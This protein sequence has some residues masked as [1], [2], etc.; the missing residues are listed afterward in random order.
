[1]KARRTLLSCLLGGVLAQAAGCTWVSSKDV[2]DRRGQVDD[3]ADGFTA[4]EDC[5]EANPNINPG[6]AEVWYDGIDQDCGRED[7]YDS[8]AD[9]YVR[10]VDVGKATAAVDGS[11]ALPGGDCDDGVATT[12]PG[13][14]DAW[15]DG[16]DTDCDGAD[17]FDADADG[18]VATEHEGLATENAPGT[19]GLPAGDCDDAVETVHPGATDAW[20]DGVDSDCRGQDDFDAD[21]D[22]YVRSED[23]GRATTYVPGSGGLP[24]G[25]CDDTLDRTRPGA[26]DAWYDGVDSDC[27]GDDDFD[28]DLDGFRDPRAPEGDGT[29]CDDTDDQ[30]WP[31]NDE[32]LG[33]TTDQDCDGVPD[34]FDLQALPSIAWTAPHDLRFAENSSTIYLSVADELVTY[35]ASSFYDSALAI[36]WDATAPLDG[37]TGL[38]AWLQNLV[39]QPFRLTDGHA[40]TATDDELLGAIGLRFES[41]GT[42]ALRLSGYDLGSLVR[43]GANAPS[44]E[45][46]AFDDIAMAVAED[47]YAHAVGCD[48]EDG[49]GAWMRATREDLTTGYDAVDEIPDLA[50]ALCTLHFFD[51]PTGTLLSVQ[52]DGL[53]SLSFDGQADTPFTD[54]YSCDTGGGDTGGGDTGCP[55]PAEV[56]PDRRLS[57]LEPVP[58]KTWLVMADPVN[59]VVVLLFPSGVEAQIPVSDP[60]SAQATVGPDNRIYVA[61]VD[62]TGTPGLAWGTVALG[63]TQVDFDPGFTATEAAVEV[64]AGGEA[65]LFATLGGS[66][67]A[68]GGALLD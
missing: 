48:D 55:D 8:D 31:G 12:A 50:A 45:A 54:L 27:A 68:V 56:D 23:V 7:D 35:G 51:D 34:R 18:Y 2:D 63:F 6:V 33:D 20:Y 26:A 4:A 24:G 38:L 16:V 57:D 65:L 44:Q 13:Q 21:G 64:T 46:A 15:Y 49:V 25:D 14:A 28:Q 59:D 29:D 37:S 43:F 22:G 58:G 52:A 1:M 5:D 11:G 62:G 3:D 9:G 66:D 36:S 47:G 10:D 53:V 32:V 30:A 39:D 61:Y 41:T 60:I 42:R 17:D 40:F 19:G 67:L